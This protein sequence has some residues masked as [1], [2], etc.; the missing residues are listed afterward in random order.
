MSWFDADVKDFAS[1]LRYAAD[2]IEYTQKVN[3]YENCNTC[4]GSAKPYC[5]YLPKWG[6]SCRINCPLWYSKTKVPSG[7][8]DILTTFGKVEDKT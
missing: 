7:N 8:T 1:L 2:C 3:S 4:G 5:P 6:E